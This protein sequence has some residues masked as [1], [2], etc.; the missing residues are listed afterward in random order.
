MENRLIEIQD[1]IDKHITPYGGKFDKN[2]SIPLSL[3]EKIGKVGLLVPTLPKKFGGKN[4]DMVEAGYLYSY[5][6]GAC[7]SVRAL[8]TVQEM[9]AHSIL[10]WGTEEQKNY[11]LP[12]L[13]SGEKVAAF[14]TTELN[15]GSDTSNI[16]STCSKAEDGYVLNGN[17]KWITFGQIADVFLVFAKYDGQLSAF[18]VERNT[19]GLSTKK[20]E[21]ML[22]MRGALHAEVLMENCVISSENILGPIGMGAH[23]SSY[24]LDFG[25]YSVAWGCIGIGQRCYKESVKYCKTRKQFGV[26]LR[27][28]QLIQGKIADML[29]MLESAR[30][31]CIKAGEFKRNSD[32][33]S[34]KATWIA[35]YSA[36][37]MATFVANEAVQIHGALGC[38]E[39]HCLE[40]FY[41]DAKIME[42]I[43]GTNEIQQIVISQ[44]EFQGS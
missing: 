21:N 26:F 43:E 42:I 3:I 4:M 24:A 7:S 41:R 27:E 34:V 33:E 32:P 19:S 38:S 44:Y 13:S 18:L 23:I 10:R 37:C 11:W 15:I 25:R 39:E 30:L 31:L 14:A 6:G 36:S 2:E 9:V 40:R 5:M 17:K 22:G 1:F 8:L 20:I 12:K 16:E 29:V 35:K 28:H